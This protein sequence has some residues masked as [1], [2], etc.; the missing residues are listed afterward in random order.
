[1]K[2][3]YLSSLFLLSAAISARAHGYVSSMLETTKLL[4]L[5]AYRPL[6]LDVIIG[7]KSYPGPSP[8][9]NSKAPTPIRQI[10]SG[11]YRNL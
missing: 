5:F 10:T 7:G 2:N 3:V 9:T 8:F 11:E 4:F 1:M 6:L